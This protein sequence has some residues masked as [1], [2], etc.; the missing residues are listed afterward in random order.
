[1]P[2]RCLS[3]FKSRNKFSLS[4]DDPEKIDYEKMENLLQPAYLIVIELANKKE[5]LKHYK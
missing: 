2:K 4:A 3:E 5:F 1:M